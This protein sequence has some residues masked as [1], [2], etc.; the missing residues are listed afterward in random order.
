MDLREDGHRRTLV[1]DP[2]NPSLPARET[3]DL[4]PDI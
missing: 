3:H 4:D 1:L 2:K